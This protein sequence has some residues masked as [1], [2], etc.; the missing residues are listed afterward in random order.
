[1]LLWHVSNLCDEVELKC[2]RL[3]IATASIHVVT[4]EKNQLQNLGK[5]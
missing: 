4:D 2:K 1:M 5:L 3:F